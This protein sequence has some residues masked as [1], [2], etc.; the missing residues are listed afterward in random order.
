MQLKVRNI[1]YIILLPIFSHHLHIY[2][3]LW[4]NLIWIQ[5]LAN[6]YSI[7]HL[8]F[9][10]AWGRK[11]I[12]PWERPKPHLRTR[13]SQASRLLQFGFIISNS[14]LCCSCF[15]L[16]L[17]CISD[18]F[19]VKV[20]RVLSQIWLYGLLNIYLVNWILFLLNLFCACLLNFNCECPIVRIVL[21][22]GW[23]TETWSLKP[24]QHRIA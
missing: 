4:N 23:R 1:S 11:R 3:K 13:V 17:W 16:S 14:I 12:H 21:G 19:V 15:I 5:F 9:A 2:I 6:L 22:S 10:R 18:N 7:F 20:K 24:D 8:I